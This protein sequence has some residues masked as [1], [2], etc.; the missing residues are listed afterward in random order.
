MPNVNYPSAWSLGKP[1]G[2]LKKEATGYR[3]TMSPPEAKQYSKYFKFDKTIDDYD[4]HAKKEANDWLRAESNKYG[5]T[6]NMIRYISKDIIEVQLTNDMIFKTDAKNILEVEKYPLNVKIKKEKGKERYYVMSQNKK[7]STTFTSQICDYKIVEY[8][9]GNTLNLCANNMKEFGSIKPAIKETETIKPHDDQYDYFNMNMDDLPKNIWILGKPA[10]TVFNRKGE[11]NI[12][13]ARVNDSDNKQHA[14]TFNIKDYDTKEKAQEEAKRWQYNTSYKLGQTTNM[15]RIIDDNL[16]EVKLTQ[17]YSMVT[18]EVFIPLIQQIPLFVKYTQVIK[19]KQNINV[20]CATVINGK[21]ILFHNFITGFLMVDH[22]DRNSLDNRLIN[23]RYTD[24]SENNRNKTTHT[25]NI[26]IR[27]IV[28]NNGYVGY[29][30]RGKFFGKQVSKIYYVHKY[31]SEEE[32]KD[33]AIMFRESALD[34]NVNNSDFNLPSNMDK[35]DLTLLTKRIEV[36]VD[37]IEKYRINKIDEYISQINLDVEPKQKMYDLYDQIQKW[38][39]NN[40]KTKINHIHIAL[41]RLEKISKKNDPKIEP[42]NTFKYVPINK[43]ITLNNK[44]E[45]D[46]I[47][48]D[49]SDNNSKEKIIPTIQKSTIF[50]LDKLSKVV[51]QRNGKILSGITDTEDDPTTIHIRCH[52]NHEFNLSYDDII[53]GKWCY[54]C[55]NSKQELQARELCKKIFNKDFIKI[56]PKWLKNHEGNSL[57]LDLY[58]D[59]MKL[60]FEVCGEQHYTY[61]KMIHGCIKNFNKQKENDKLKKDLCTKHKITLIKIPHYVTNLEEYIILKSAKHD[62]LK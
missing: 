58:N 8:I 10:G 15:I 14:K 50:S 47:K 32:A 53:L 28:E 2:S 24:H 34:V 25:E 6:R 52:D 56:K 21:I 55:N 33:K 51:K 62:V 7:I 4:K 49:D 54:F 48:D 5:L 27:R 38:Q 41:N 57:E 31:A 61:N 42:S 44:L 45:S 19:T 3:V 26:G 60:A 18:D 22:I 40:L 17:E 36:M 29:E 13:T 23:L 39:I 11:E 20:Y 9:D 12:Y 37:D 16:I 46:F 1:R 59:E 30:A 35:K 43:I